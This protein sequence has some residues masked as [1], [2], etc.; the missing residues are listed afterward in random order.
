MRQARARRRRHARSCPR[1]PLTA[2]EIAERRRRLRRACLRVQALPA[3]NRYRSELKNTA[4][5]LIRYLDEHWRT[6][7][8][9]DDYDS[10]WP[11]IDRYAAALASDSFT[12]RGA[13]KRLRKLL[14]R[15]QRSPADL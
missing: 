5:A 2:R 1:P 7:G 13:F 10:W 14:D 6:P 11:F 9:R 12:G 15:D 4:L 8:W 3:G